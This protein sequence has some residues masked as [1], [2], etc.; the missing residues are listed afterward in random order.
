MELFEDG[1]AV[2]TALLGG[3]VLWYVNGAVEVA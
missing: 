2:A 3:E 1:F